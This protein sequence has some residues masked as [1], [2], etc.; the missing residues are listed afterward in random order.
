[1]SAESSK[2]GF[3]TPGK[4]RWRRFAIAAVPAVAIAGVLVGLTAEGA[5]ASSISVSGEE[6]TVTATQLTGTGFEQFGGEVSNASGPQPVIVS[7]INSA[8]LT[9]LCQSVKIGPVTLRLT[10]GTGGTPAS[11]SNMIV[12]ASGQTG[13]EATFKNISIGLDAGTL[14]EDPGA[15]GAAGSFGEQADTVTIDNLNQDTWLTT[16][17]TFTLPDL[18]LGFGGSC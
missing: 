17:G 15:S 13:S 18:S 9:G 7:A 12:D 4:V 5:I 8:K 3:H 14:T 2:A 16:A 11:A 1:M 10:A 6:Y